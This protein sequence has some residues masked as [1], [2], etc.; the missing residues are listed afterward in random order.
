MNRK[1][2]AAQTMAGWPAPRP[3]PAPGFVEVWTWPLVAEA[4]SLAALAGLLSE[5]EA[6]R[7]E[8]FLNPVLGREFVA[9]RAG[10]RL[11]LAAYAGAPAAALRFAEGP[12]GKPRLVPPA[13]PVLQFNLSHSAGLAALGV[14]T[15]VEIG[16]DIEARRPVEPGVAER[17]FAP[18]ERLRLGGLAGEEWTA[19]FFRCWTRKE[20][21][22]KATGDGLCL[23]L[24]GFE[25]ALLPDEPVAVLSADALPMGAT[26]WP[27]LSFEPAPAVAGAV[28]VVSPFPH[29]LVHVEN[30]GR[31]FLDRQ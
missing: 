28:A 12:R 7:A 24:D 20:A 25:V 23:P 10:L 3:F 31:S 18:G 11:I 19:G 8:R 27:L 21:L 22:I 17:F 29:R 6:A 26:S 15:G 14:A 5:D 4:D 2:P 13:G 16:V 1:E 30:G 9:A